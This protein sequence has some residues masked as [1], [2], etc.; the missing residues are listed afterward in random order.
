MTCGV[1]VINGCAVGGSDFFPSYTGQVIYASLVGATHGALISGLVTTLKTINEKMVVEAM[2]AAF[3][4]LAVAYLMGPALV[5]VL[6]DFLD[7]YRYGIQKI[8]VIISIS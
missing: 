3:L 8:K 2:G 6:F 1:F 7:S 5:A 4:H